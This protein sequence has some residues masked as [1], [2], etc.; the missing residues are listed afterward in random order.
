MLRSQSEHEFAENTYVVVVSHNVLKE[1][2]L[3]F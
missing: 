2:T 1:K 3:G